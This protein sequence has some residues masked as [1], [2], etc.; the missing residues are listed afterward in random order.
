MGSLM[1]IEGSN[2]SFSANHPVAKLHFDFGAQR[3][4]NIHARAEL[5][6]ADAVAALDGVV[7]G[8]PRD[9]APRDE[10]A[11]KGKA[12]FLAGWLADIKA[13]EHVFIEF[14]AVSFH[15]VQIL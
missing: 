10:G 12:D 14:R 4:I 1:L 8:D 15:R 2:H 9:D 3:Q 11:V 7:L 13:D 6:E 5:D